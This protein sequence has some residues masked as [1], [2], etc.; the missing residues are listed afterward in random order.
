MIAIYFD[1]NLNRGRN[2]ILFNTLSINPFPKFISMRM[3]TDAVVMVA[4]EMH[5]ILILLPLCGIILLYF[6]LLV[7]W[8]HTKPFRFAFEVFQKKGKKD[9]FKT[10]ERLFFLAKRLFSI[11]CRKPTGRKLNKCE[12]C[13][14]TDQ[15]QYGMP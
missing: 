2:V 12:L 4:T 9:A 8:P 7:S 10:F 14:L 5:L 11:F 3:L 15:R 1:Y 6:F 13:A